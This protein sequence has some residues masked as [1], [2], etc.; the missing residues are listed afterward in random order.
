[1]YCWILDGEIQKFKQLKIIDINNNL[2]SEEARK[3]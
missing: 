1:M 3:A 2:E